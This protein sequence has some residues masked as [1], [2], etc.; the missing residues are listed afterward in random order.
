M[1]AK[2]SLVAA[3]V[4]LAGKSSLLVTIEHMVE[5]CGAPTWPPTQPVRDPSSPEICTRHL[6]MA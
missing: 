4:L 5:S 1:P 3:I 2:R 6:G